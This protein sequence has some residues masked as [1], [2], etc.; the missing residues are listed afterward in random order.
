MLDV[1]TEL[2]T[3]LDEQRRTNRTLEREMKQKNVDIEAVST[4]FDQC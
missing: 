2:K 4:V 1:V 3:E